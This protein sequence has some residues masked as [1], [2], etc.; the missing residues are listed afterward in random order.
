MLTY[1]HL[2]GTKQCQVS[3]TFKMGRKLQEMLHQTY[4]PEHPSLLK[5]AF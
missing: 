2:S 3:V 1:I 4:M 5:F